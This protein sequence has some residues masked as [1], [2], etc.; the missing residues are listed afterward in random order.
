MATFTVSTSAQLTTALS[1]ASGGDKILLAAGDYGRL[2]ISGQYATALTITSADPGN[3]AS[4]SS[5][6]VDG[7]QNVTL[8]RVLFDYDFKV[9][10]IATYKPFEVVNSSNIIIQNSVFN[11]DVASGLGTIFDGYGT[12]VGLS[13]RSSSGVQVG[14]NEFKSWGTA[15]KVNESQNV[16][17]EGNNIHDIRK[18]GMNFVEVQGVVIENNYIHDFK[19][20]PDAIDHRDMIQ[21]WTARTDKPSTDIVIRNNVLDIANGSHTQSIFMRNDLVDRGLA[22]QEM[23]YQNVLIEGNVIINHHSHGI[24]VG[25]TNGLVI[26][27]NTLVA[28]KPDAAEPTTQWLLDKYGAGSGILVPRINVSDDSSGVSIKTNS[29]YGADYFTGN[30]IDS[31]PGDIVTGNVSY[32]SNPGP[33]PGTVYGGTGGGNTGGGTGG[34]DTGGATGGGTGGATGGGGGTGGGTGLPVLDDYVTNF[35]SLV[36]TTAL[37]GNALV[38]NGSAQLDGTGD[39][40]NLGRLSAFDTSD[41]LSFSVDFSRDVANGGEA[42]LVWNHQNLGLVL[43][44]DGLFIKVAGADGKFKLFSS[45]DLDLNDTDKH[46]IRVIVD[47][48]TDRLQV[49]VDGGVAIDRSD[50]DLDL[51]MSTGRDWWLGGAKWGT[52]LDGQITDFSLEADATFF[53]D[54]GDALQQDAALF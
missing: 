18:D 16:V 3:P 50:V 44:G 46:S 24:T 8:D 23:Y 40:V 14:N 33:T 35:V 13:V 2:E 31:G 7:A 39:Y 51:G 52:G 17:V 37:Q 36:G 5:M 41:A 43:K 20:L 29:F 26:Q 10:D 45:G 54:V 32:P 6:A 9:S 49:I 38:K 27:N 30:R 12:G 11:G 53:S 42:R 48:A 1:Q 34:V 25:E 22:G 15:L 19:G 47:S 4:F 28:A 21:F